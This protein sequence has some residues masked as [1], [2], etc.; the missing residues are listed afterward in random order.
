MT[1]QKYGGIR[2]GHRI[3][4]SMTSARSDASLGRRRGASYAA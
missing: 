2:L 3:V 1:D 4:P